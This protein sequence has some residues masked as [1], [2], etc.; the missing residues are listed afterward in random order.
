MK[1]TIH[2][3]KIVPAYF[4]AIRFGEKKFEIR[5]NDRNFH[6]GDILRLKEWD[7]ENFTGEEIDVRVRFILLE[8]Q[9]AIKPGY[10]VMS[11]DTMV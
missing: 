9:D 4:D 1:Q 5:K 11:I 6:V 10:C 2:E 7:G 8:W 3:L